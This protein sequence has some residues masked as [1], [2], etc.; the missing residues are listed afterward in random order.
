MGV[1][2]SSPFCILKTYLAAENWKGD[3]LFFN[4]L[5]CGTQEISIYPSQLVLDASLNIVVENKLCGQ[6][7]RYSFTSWVSPQVVKLTKF[8]FT[9]FE[10]GV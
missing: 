3:S 5:F 6:S 9:V 10:S 1:R 7:G 2:R 8:G 4:F